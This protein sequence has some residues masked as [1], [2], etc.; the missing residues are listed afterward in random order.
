MCNSQQNVFPFYFIF[1]LIFAHVVCIYDQ[2]IYCSIVDQ[3]FSTNLISD[4][5]ALLSNVPKL[6]MLVFSDDIMIMMQGPSFPTV[7]KTLQTTLQTIEDWCKEHRLEISK[8]KSALMPMITRNTEKY[9][10][11]PK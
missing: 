8:D 3:F 9:K 2:C 4:L 10:R 7:L 1:G 11:H 6:K 5:Q